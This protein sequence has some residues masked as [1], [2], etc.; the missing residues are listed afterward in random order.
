MTAQDPS[1]ESFHF[2][3]T[4][5]IMPD[6]LSSLYREWPEQASSASDG[7]SILLFF[8]SRHVREQIP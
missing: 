8:V 4:L 1:A 6:L 7:A 2:T 5:S 3:S